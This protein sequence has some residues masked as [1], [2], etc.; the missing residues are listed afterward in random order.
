MNNPS[1]DGAVKLILQIEGLCVLF[2]SILAYGKLG[3]GWKFFFLLFLV[4]DVSMIVYLLNSKRGHLIYNV[5]HSYSFP[6]LL[7][8]TGIYFN[9][10]ASLATG[11]IWTAHIGFDRML[12]YGLKYSSG[13]RFTHLGVIGRRGAAFRRRRGRP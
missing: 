13:F 1:A 4:P 10:P 11:L 8:G 3:I 5:A 6:L 2:L 12:G 9:A 7:L